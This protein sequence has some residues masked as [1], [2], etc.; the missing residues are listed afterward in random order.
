MLNGD[1]LQTHLFVDFFLQCIAYSFVG[2]YFDTEWWWS[3]SFVFA[4]VLITTTN[5]VYEKIKIIQVHC[6]GFFS[7]IID[8]CIQSS[9][10][11][12]SLLHNILECGFPFVTTKNTVFPVIFWKVQGMKGLKFIIFMVRVKWALF[13]QCQLGLALFWYN[14][15]LSN[16]QVITRSQR[17]GKLVTKSPIEPGYQYTDNIVGPYKMNNSK[18]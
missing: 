18:F 9:D 11:R 6:M 13:L 3:V 2:S 5:Y 8:L 16:V 10:Y 4:T 14:N 17:E 1:I 15:V 7:F 12:I